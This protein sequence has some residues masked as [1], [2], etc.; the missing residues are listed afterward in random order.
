[1]TFAKGVTSGCL[2]VGGVIVR[3]DIVDVLVAANQEFA[4]GYTYSG[5]P[6]A[7]AAALKNMEI[8]EREQLLPHVQELGPY[9]QEQLKT[10]TDLPIV[11]DVR[12]VGLMACVEFVKT[13]ETKDLFSEDLDIGK[14]VSNQAESRSIMF[15]H[16][17]NLNALYP[18]FIIKHT[19]VA[20]ITAH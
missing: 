1:M 10:L 4:H 2:P 19:P 6:V 13:K 18:P 3:D 16:I 14:W 20:S 8:M 7:C 12:G 5:H 9:F 15:H 17:I 11:G